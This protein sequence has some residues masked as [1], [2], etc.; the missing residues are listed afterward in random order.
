MTDQPEKPDMDYL[1]A[2]FYAGGK[3][4]VQVAETWVTTLLDAHANLRENR[5]PGNPLPNWEDM[6]HGA[7][8]RK[9]VGRLLDAGWRPPSDVERA[10]AVAWVAACQRRWDRW[11]NA[12]TPSD[13]A[14]FVAHYSEHGEP[15][16]HLRPPK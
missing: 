3:D 16:S 7:L 5:P 9:I 6:T 11:W 13:Q 15:P 12:L 2:E 1:S 8:A 4:G 10:A 14:E